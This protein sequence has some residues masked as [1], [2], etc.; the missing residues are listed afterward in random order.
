MGQRWSAEGD[1]GYTAVSLGAG[2]DSVGLQTCL[3]STSSEVL[4]E[5]V[6]F[7]LL[8]YYDAG[9]RRG[10]WLEYYGMPIS[11]HNAMGLCPKVHKNRESIQDTEGGSEWVQLSHP[12]RCLP[13]L[14]V[15]V[16]LR[17]KVR[18]WW[19][20]WPEG[21]SQ[22]CPHITV[23]QSERRR[24]EDKPGSAEQTVSRDIQRNK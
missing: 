19:V 9:W 14:G 5:K 15:L 11:T 22:N 23:Y 6:G 2:G 18:L 21:K 13:N 12:H 20:D 17:T 1:L 4:Y 16:R 24:T 7:W 8:G 3:W 10:T